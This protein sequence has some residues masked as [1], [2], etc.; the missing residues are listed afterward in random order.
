MARPACQQQLA[1]VLLMLAL[2]LA[3]PSVISA[4]TCGQ[5]AGYLNPCISYAMGHGSAPPEAC[6]SGVRNL[7]AAARSTADRQAACKC[8]K[9]ITGSMPALKPDIVAGIPSKCGVD[10]PYPIRPSTDCAKVQ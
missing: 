7:N 9:Q 1:V 4:V 5:V 6:C 2:F 3:A 10:I 8:L